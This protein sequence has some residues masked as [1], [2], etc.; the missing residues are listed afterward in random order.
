MT[1]RVFLVYRRDDRRP[2]GEVRDLV[3]VRSGDTLLID[4]DTR[5]G[6]TPAAPTT[7]RKHRG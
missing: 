7:T 4:G 1:V 6:G 5:I 3:L 2:Q